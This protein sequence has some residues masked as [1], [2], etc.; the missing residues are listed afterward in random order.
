MLQFSKTSFTSLIIASFFSS[1]ITSANI[2]PKE[3]K[4][5]GIWQVSAT[6][7]YFTQSN[8]LDIANSII[9]PIGLLG[10][11]IDT[12]PE[13]DFGYTAALG[14]IFPSHKYDLQGSFSWINSDK[15]ANALFTQGSDFASRKSDL[16]YEYNEA[17]IT[18][19]N[20]FKLNKRF[21][22]RF[23]YGLSY[24]AI[25][26]KSTDYFN[27]DDAEFFKENSENKFWGIGPKFTLDNLFSFT[28]S[29]SFV[30]RLGASLLFGQSESFISSAF[31]PVA[32]PGSTEFITGDLEQTRATFGFDGELG[33]RWDQ[34]FN[35]DFS[36][37]LE[38]GY[39]GVTYLN[40]LQDMGVAIGDPT[41]FSTG[42]GNQGNYYNYGPY[43]TFGL[44]FF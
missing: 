28:P 12:Q 43:V 2:F 33:L 9:P 30:G 17:E 14:Y 22:I 6:G 19:G 44:D 40:A 25:K 13:Q 4:D 7:I 36:F 23:G 26:Q 38:A 21:L 1:G 32:Q 41:A 31:Y 24:V 15:T 11:N 27:I 3:S 34:D 8:N 37:N 5:E 10:L 20:Y 16:Q 29:F 42:L 35:D 39:Q 18:L